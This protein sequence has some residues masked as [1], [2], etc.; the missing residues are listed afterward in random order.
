MLPPDCAETAC[1]NLELPHLEFLYLAAKSGRE[2]FDKTNVLRH[3]EMREFL[4][5]IRANLFLIYNSAILYPYPGDHGF[6]QP[7][8]GNPDDLNVRNARMRVKQLL[9]LTRSMFSPP[10]IIMS[11][12]RPVM[13]K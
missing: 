1:F 9:D 13:R 8:V 10:R 11:F 6:A 2:A 3:L 4:P 7:R 5:A 12:A